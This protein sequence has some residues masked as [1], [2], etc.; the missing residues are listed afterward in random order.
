MRRPKLK[1][2]MRDRADQQYIRGMDPCGQ[3]LGHV[4]FFKAQEI[5]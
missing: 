2:Q 1:A 4:F 3:P 5:D